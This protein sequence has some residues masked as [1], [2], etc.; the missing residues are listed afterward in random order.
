LSSSEDESYIIDNDDNDTT[1]ARFGGRNNSRNNN[2]YTATRVF[3]RNRQLQSTTTTANDVESGLTD[4][5]A[6]TLGPTGGDVMTNGGEQTAAENCRNYNVNNDN[7]AADEHYFNN[8]NYKSARYKRDSAARDVGGGGDS[9]NAGSEED[10]NYRPPRV[11]NY[12]KRYVGNCQ[13][14]RRRNM[15]AAARERTKQYQRGDNVS[16]DID[17]ND[18]DRSKERNP[19]ETVRKTL[20]GRENVSEVAS[21]LAQKPQRAWIDNSTGGMRYSKSRRSPRKWQLLPLPTAPTHKPKPFVRYHI[22]MSS[23]GTLAS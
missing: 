21:Q 1:T 17:D 16:S 20:G 18:S 23:E 14:D 6:E 12:Y 10:S 4:G 9:K 19:G 11:N 7:A 15:N 2:N 3:Y 5:L 13:Q 8:F 22:H